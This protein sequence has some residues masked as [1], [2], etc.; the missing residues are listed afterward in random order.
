MTE[1]AEGD[2]KPAPEEKPAFDEKLRPFINQALK[3]HLRRPPS[4]AILV[5]Q[6]KGQNWKFGPHHRDMEAWH[7]Q[8]FDAFGTRSTSTFWTFIDQLACLCFGEPDYGP[9]GWCPNEAELNA[10]INMVSGT[11]PRNEMEAALAAQMVAV[12]LMTMQLS[13][14]ALRN[15]YGDPKTAAAAGKLARTFAMQCETMAKLKGR[16]GKQRITVKYERHNHNHQ[17]Q[18]VHAEIAGG[19]SEN[20]GRPHEPTRPDGGISTIEHEPG[21][22]LSGPDTTRD[23]M[24]MP[25]DKGS[26]TVPTPRRRERVRRVQGGA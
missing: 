12:H 20:F 26:N 6:D 18:H 17:H 9:K 3:R 15:A 5:E 1:T 8:L 21:P 13:A 23:A 7:V 11:R 24:P 25:C 2:L 16:A 10:A 19:V 4:P 14:R 22:S